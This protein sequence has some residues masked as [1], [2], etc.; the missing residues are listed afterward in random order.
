MYV[1]GVQLHEHRQYRISNLCQ[2]FTSSG[3]FLSKWIV[4]LVPALPTA[5]VLLSPLQLY[6]CTLV[7]HNSGWSGIPSGSDTVW[8]A[9]NT[10]NRWLEEEDREA[11]AHAM[12]NQKDKRVEK[13]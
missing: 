11:L 13:V 9:A 12:M 2:V 6:Y 10:V 7:T 1:T 4:R 5:S 3:A 8:S